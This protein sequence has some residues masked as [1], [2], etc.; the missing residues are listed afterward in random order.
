MQYPKQTDNYDVDIFNANF[1]ELA[2]NVISLDTE[3]FDK[4][5]AQGLFKDVA[6]NK[7]NGVITF[8]LY[9]GSVKTIDTLLEKLAVNFDF[10][11]E[12]QRLIITLDD[13]T[14]KYV[15]LSAFITQYEFLDSETIAFVLGEDGKVSA[16]IKEGSIEEKHLRP[17]YL[18]D[19]KTEAAKAEAARQDAQESQRETEEAEANAVASAA[20]SA[21]N[22]NSAR[23]AAEVALEAKTKAQ[24]A[25]V[26]AESYAHGGTGTREGEDTDNA[27]F[28]YQQSKALH[29]DILAA[30]GASEENAGLMSAHDKSWV[31]GKFRR[32]V[33][34][35]DKSGDADNGYYKIASVETD[36][37]YRTFGLMLRLWSDN[38][39]NYA[40]NPVE[41]TIYFRT[42]NNSVASSVFVYIDVN[43][44]ASNFYKGELIFIKHSANP[45]TSVPNGTEKC[46]IYFNRRSPY[47][48]IVVEVLGETQRGSTSS[49]E[50]Y[51]NVWTFYDGNEVVDEIEEEGFE[52]G[53][54]IHYAAHVYS[55]VGDASTP[56]FLENGILKPCTDLPTGGTTN[57]NDLENKPSINGIELSG[58]KTASNLMVVKST[59]TTNLGINKP[60]IAIGYVSGTT[61]IYGNDDGAMY[62]HAYSDLWCHQIYGDYRTGQ[63]A[64]RG[65]NNGTWQAWRRQLDSGN[66]IGYATA[67]LPHQHIRTSGGANGYIKLKINSDCRHNNMFSATIRVYQNYVATDILVS[68]Y[69][70][71]SNHWHQPK[72]TILGCSDDI[73]MPVSFGYDSDGLEWIAIRVYDYYGISV[74]G[75]ND[76]YT[77]TSNV[78]KS[79]FFTFVFEASITG[80][81]QASYTLYPPVIR[82]DNGNVIVNMDL[83]MANGTIYFNKSI[84]SSG[85]IATNWWAADYGGGA[86]YYGYAIMTPPGGVGGFAVGKSE[87]NGAPAL[88]SVYAN[89]T[90]GK[91]DAR[92][93][94]IYTTTAISVSSDSREKTDQKPLDEELTEKFVLG[95]N[96]KSYKRIDGTSGRRHHGLI[97]PEVEELME[98]LG[99]SSLDFA[100]F[101]KS[102]KTEEIEEENPETGE[103]T[104]TYKEIEGE[105]IY[106]LRYEEFIPMLIKM[107]QIQHD[108]IKALEEENLQLSER[109]VR[110]EDYL[111]LV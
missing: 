37:T 42:N 12:T 13:G 46:E 17:N 11:R 66:Y 110:I 109:M 8:T 33:Y 15:D 60:D 54:P 92:W 68:G 1:R 86:S 6:F 50:N 71:G 78:E 67:F 31:D 103:M 30:G 91:A 73:S 80:T 47:A 75:F 108:K 85:Y 34:G 94:T 106:S 52:V 24:K 16:K 59:G 20:A 89:Q 23:T 97:A 55:N 7:G 83:K 45:E 36:R 95:L 25:A 88:W 111:E 87:K 65:R 104:K 10:D 81:T 19:I 48:K 32:Y 99:I 61:P 105:Y 107:I 96:P 57:Y 14:E 93:G 98:S 76:S 41:M 35:A 22:A 51:Q 69:L 3:K 29:D 84:P 64:T 28:Y 58:N 77:G 38:F 79:K 9:D 82:D 102:P 26:D 63:I 70:Y 40:T 5:E 100:G 18:A 2:G 39:T 101:I 90:L 44:G 21:E 56:I 53:S 43:S 62:E 72:A 49:E 4:T 74:L 27:D